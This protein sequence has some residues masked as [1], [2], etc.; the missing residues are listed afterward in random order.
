MARTM[1][2]TP[3]GELVGYPWINKADDKFNPDNP[4]Y[5]AD[6]ALDADEAQPLIDK[7]EGL[8][9]EAFNAHVDDL[10]PA[11]KKLWSIYR[12][13]EDELDEETGE[14][15]GRIVF[16]TKQNSI[17]KTKSGEEKTITIGIRSASD[18]PMK[19]TVWSGSTVR[20]MFSTR[21]IEMSSAKQVGIR[22]DLAMV[23]VK[24][25]SSGVSRGFGAVEGYTEDDADQAFDSAESS[26]NEEVGEY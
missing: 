21:P 15:T 12:P 9:Q 23:Q 20:L 2:I 7:L 14:P 25:L 13:W 19:A 24:E 10:P 5:K 22:L 16:K 11:K 3:F 17:I 4:V 26:N 6:L 1:H 8:V 18:K